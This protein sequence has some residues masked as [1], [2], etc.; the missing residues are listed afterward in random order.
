[1]LVRAMARGVDAG[2][3]GERIGCC[4]DAFYLARL[5][6]TGEAAGRLRWAGQLH[7]VHAMA[8]FACATF[9]NIGA[10]TARH[11]ALAFVLGDGS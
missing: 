9:M 3:S 11:A 5:G 6:F 8:A 2:G 7:L 10:P 1:M 4:G